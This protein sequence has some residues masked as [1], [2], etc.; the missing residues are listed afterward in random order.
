MALSD[1]QK[2]KLGDFWAERLGA[3]PENFVKA[4]VSFFEMFPEEMAWF[5]DLQ[6]RKEEALA[7]RDRG[8]WRAIIEEEKNKIEEIAKN[9]EK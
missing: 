3:A 5:E 8:A 6:K 1:E 7:K 4:I 2:K 9:H